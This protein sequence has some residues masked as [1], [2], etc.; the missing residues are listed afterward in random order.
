MNW[1]SR[2]TA[3]WIVLA[4]MGLTMAAPV[5]AKLPPCP[6]HRYRLLTA[7]KVAQVYVGEVLA[8]TEGFGFP[9]VFG[10]TYTHRRS[11]ELGKLPP[12]EGHAVAGGISSIALG[13]PMVAFEDEGV[14]GT[15]EES[16]E[17]HYI[18]VRDLRNG[19]TVHRVPNGVP[20][21][22]IPLDVGVGVTQ[23]IVVKGD[24]SVA[25]TAHDDMRS[26]GRGYY[27]LEVLDAK[28]YR[29]VASGFTVS[30]TSLQLHGSTLSWLDA[31]VH[32][33]AMLY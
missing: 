15:I 6:R 31:G 25:W 32:R 26:K 10:C 22:E 14:S 30:P 28:G 33:T 19:H 8:D 20:E 5:D 12:S 4:G 2:L 1:M 11:Y 9:A 17:R 29:L 24:G 27:D 21:V 7:D 3:I 16:A 13:G 23:V 18:V